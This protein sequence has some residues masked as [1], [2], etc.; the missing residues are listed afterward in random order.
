MKVLVCIPCL[1]TGGTEIQ[2]LNLVEA[3]VAAGHNVVTVCYFEYSPDMVNRYRMAGSKVELMNAG[4]IRP[5]GI[6]DTA[7]Q[8]FKGF[9]EIIRRYKPDVVHVQYMA[10]G[11]LPIII[12]RL[13]GMKRI[14]A[15]AHT[16]ADI[17]PSLK[18]L[19]FV[20][21]YF[22]IAFQCIT[23][24]A[25]TSFFGTSKLYDPNLKLS[26]RGN[27]FTIYNNLPPYIAI[28][29]TERTF[30]GK[31]ITIGVVSRLEPIKGMD[32]VVPAFERI[33]AA[34]P[35]ARLLVV[36]DGS[37]RQLMEHQIS[38]AR[39]NKTIVF[40]N[41][42]PQHALQEYYDQIDI[43]LMPS[44]S[45]GF[46]LTAIEGMARGCVLVAADTGGLPEVV[47]DGEVGLLHKYEN[48]QD[49]ADKVN[50]LLSNPEKM[51]LMSRKAMER[52]SLFST[53]RYQS[54]IKDLYNK[55][56]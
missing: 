49:I 44:R 26:S 25:E 31:N 46:G 15:T 24:R 48:A 10:P 5:K 45:E 23:K 19:H 21:R 47:K 50:G 17:Y 52:V 41:Q 38:N 20:T 2:T 12:L 16:P 11:A 8:L 30:N 39:L 42:Q 34:N 3:L 35:T 9:K 18:L 33:H 13:L 54:L 14:V 55:L 6:K 36:G 43:L 27:H 51:S 4:G 32:L 56:S 40:A 22:L 7:L 29:N 28:A 53:N 37:Q 1:M